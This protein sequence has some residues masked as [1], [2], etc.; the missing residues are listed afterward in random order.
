MPVKKETKHK[1]YLAIISIVL[2]VL[3]M[4]FMFSGDNFDLLK[5]LFTSDQSNEELR[6]KLNDFGW[7]G[8][9][10]ITVL[11]VLQVVCAF[12]PAEPI[13]VLSGL[14]FGFPIGLLCCWLGVF[15]GSSII[16]QLY[17]S[18]GDNLSNFFV[19][20]LHLDL[21]KIAQSSKCVLIIFI[22]Q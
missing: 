4:L 6:D 12:L 14:T 17:N 21:E 3:L 20:K 7:R 13:Q 18:F 10:T 16:Y 22:I 19:K 2:F 15:I 8:Y 9:I 5:S 1:L 11:S